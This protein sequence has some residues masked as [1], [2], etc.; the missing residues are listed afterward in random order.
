M[1]GAGERRARYAR[2]RLRSDVNP[3]FR[4]ERPGT[5]VGGPSQIL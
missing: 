5:S 1:L 2:S 4:R 3:E